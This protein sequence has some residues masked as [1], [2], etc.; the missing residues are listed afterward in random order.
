MY[1][2]RGHYSNFRTAHDATGKFQQFA[3]TEFVYN[4]QRTVV[5]VLSA[6]DIHGGMVY[7]LDPRVDSCQ[8]LELSTV[9]VL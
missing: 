3:I 7:A 4:Q 5:N 8:L 9:S 1:T 6:A 2:Q